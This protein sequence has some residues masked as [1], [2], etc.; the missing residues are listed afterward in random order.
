MK[1]VHTTRNKEHASTKNKEKRARYLNDHSKKFAYGYVQHSFTPG[2]SLLEDAAG[3]T[4][5]DP[6]T[7]DN[8]LQEKWGEVMAGNATSHLHT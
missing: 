1:K 4:T 5:G 7:M 6:V 2:L 8:I 3:N